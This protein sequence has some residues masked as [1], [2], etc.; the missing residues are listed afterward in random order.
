MLVALL[1]KKNGVNKQCRN[2]RND[3]ILCLRSI[4]AHRNIQNDRD[5]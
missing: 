2:K 4:N 1:G 3:Q 5:L